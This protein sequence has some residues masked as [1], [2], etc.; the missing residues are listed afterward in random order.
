MKK[1]LYSLF[2]C[3]SLV[4][5]SCD[6]TTQD[7]SFITYY[8]DFEMNGDKIMTVEL[9]TPY[10]EPGVVA[11]E[12]GKDISSK[13]VTKG[14]DKVD[15]NKAGVYFITY[16]A[17]N[18]DGY[19]SEVTRM[20]AVYDP[21]ITTDISGKYS[22]SLDSNRQMPKVDENGEDMVD[23]D[24]NY[25]WDDGAPFS[26][27]FSVSIKKVAPGIFYISDMM[28]GYYDQGRGYG[29]DYA[30]EA[31][32]SL[33]GGAATT[34]SIVSGGT[35]AFGGE[36]D[37]LTNVSYNPDVA[38]ADGIYPGILKWSVEYQGMLFNVVLD[39]AVEE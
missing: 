36:Y 15:V 4:M 26:N 30:M 23:E 1:L 12:Q 16:S 6:D 32:V 7:P 39:K 25:I 22:T 11:K 20:V 38:P 31:Y 9:G 5:A 29:T 28:G 3:L 14:A 37:A 24:K 10:V 2:V 33:E 17:A 18:V 35:S 34:F 13:I 21:A 8:V 27:N 19:G